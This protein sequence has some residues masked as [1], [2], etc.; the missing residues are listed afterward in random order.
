MADTEPIFSKIGS[1]AAL[2]THLLAAISTGFVKNLDE[3]Y[4]FIDSTF[5]AYQSDTFALKDEIDTTLDFLIENGF[6]ERINKDQF[7]PTLFGNRTSS[8]YIDPLSALQLRK[9][10]EESCGR[11]TSSLSFLHAV[12]YILE[13][14]MIGLMKKQR[15]N[16]ENFYLK[17]LIFQ[18]MITNGSLVI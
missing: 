8:L 5:Y 15:E 7:M 13:K 16:M 4:K 9:A 6:V 12:H 18:A 17:H 3:I 10:L 14:V 2:R 11:S 1:Q